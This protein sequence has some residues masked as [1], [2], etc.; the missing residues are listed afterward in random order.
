MSAGGKIKE[1]KKIYN[2]TPYDVCIYEGSVPIMSIPSTGNA[3]CSELRDELYRLKYINGSITM[4]VTQV[5]YGIVN[6]LPAPSDGVVY[7]VSKMVADAKHHIPR[8]DLY[9]PGE[10]KRNVKGEIIGCYGLS[11]GIY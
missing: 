1:V 5:A 6:E 11:K 9:Y 8:D 2:F 10:L 3:R 4:P 7:I